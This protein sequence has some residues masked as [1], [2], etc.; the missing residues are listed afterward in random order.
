M[1][2]D[3]LI[4]LFSALG[5]TL[6]VAVGAFLT[7]RFS[8]DTSDQQKPVYSRLQIYSAVNSELSKIVRLHKSMYGYIE[9][10]GERFFGE[11]HDAIFNGRIAKHYS[12]IKVQLGEN[13]LIMSEAFIEVLETMT[14]ELD[15]NDPNEIPPE[16]QKRWDKVITR[17]RTHL[18]GQAK[19]ELKVVRR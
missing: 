16:Q 5:A 14:A 17:T 4:A 13:Y 3:M 12:K 15:Y 2:K 8:R 7:T 11:G 10:D 9:G 1:N 18:I 19:Q 6:S